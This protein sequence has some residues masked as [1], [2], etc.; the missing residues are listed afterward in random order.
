VDDLNYGIPDSDIHFYITAEYKPDEFF[1]A[2]AAY[3]QLND[4]DYRPILA[5]LHFNIAN[6]KSDMFP[7]TF[8]S[9]LDTAIH[10]MCHAMAFSI[11]LISAF[12]GGQ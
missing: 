9:H 11:K 1:I 7:E 3:C 12:P 5:R 6:Y 4:G 2:W 8:N 10:E